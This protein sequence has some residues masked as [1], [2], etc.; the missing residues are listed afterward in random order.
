MNLRFFK[1]SKK[2]S[3]KYRFDERQIIFFMCLPIVAFFIW[4]SYNYNL[5]KL[6]S[7]VHSAIESQLR[8]ASGSSYARSSILPKNKKFVVPF[9]IS[10]NYLIK[11]TKSIQKPIKLAYVNPGPLQTDSAFAS[12]PSWSQNFK[13]QKTSK[14]NANDWN[15]YVGQPNNSNDEAEYYTNSSTNL[16]I[17]NGALSLVA[18]QQA[19]PNGY[20]YA[21]ARIDTQNKQSF[22]YGRIDIKAEVPIGDGVWPAAWLLPANN[23]YEYLS[24]PSD[25]DR[26]MNGGEIDLIEEVGFD[27]NTEYGIVHSISDINNPNGVGD[28]NT[29][30]VPNGSNTYN[31]YS[32]LWTPS[33]ITFE[34]NNVPF[35]TYTKATHAN[36]TT[37]PF[38]QPFYLI[39]NLALGGSWGGEDK[40]AFPGNGIDNS[41]LPSSFNIQSIYY[42]PYIGS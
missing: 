34:V 13:N 38:D 6:Y 20:D 7:G 25:I 12:Y 35:Y 14:L 24:P 3:I 31:L 19:E 9:N 28:Y 16:Y 37:W 40:S 23:K 33:Y 22:L 39:L 32:V 4:G 30:V 26:Y 15:I 42:Y 5:Y 8:I 21:S 18:T 17:K 1:K 10:G 11:P 36:Y 2:K 27:P 29:V 41:I